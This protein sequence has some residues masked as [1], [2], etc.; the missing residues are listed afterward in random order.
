MSISRKAL[1]FVGCAAL[2]ACSAME[3]PAASTSTPR[4]LAKWVIVSPAAPTIAPGASLALDVE[5]QDASGRDITGQPEAWST[6]DSTIAT[7]SS[8]G[9]VTG[10]A[11]G[12][13]KIFIASGAQ[14]AYA[15]LTVS[16]APPAPR[17]VSVAPATAQVSVHATM[18]LFASVTDA[19]GHQVSNVPV[20]WSSSNTA[21]AMVDTSGAITG[22]APGTASIIV[23]AGTNQA[24]AQL[25]VVTASTVVAPAPPPPAPLQ[26]PPSSGSLYSG[27]NAVSPH[28][29]HIRTMM[30]DFYYGWTSP[31]RTWAGQH[32]D[33]AMSGTGSAWRAVNSSVGHLTYT[34]E[35]TTII[36]GSSEH[37]NAQTAY[38]HDMVAWYAAHGSYS[39][40]NAFLHKAGASHDSASRIVIMIW[41][42]KRW[43]V[44]PADVGA[45]NYQVDRYQRIVAGENGAFVDEA[46]N[47][48]GQTPASLEFPMKTDFQAP[49]TATFAAIKQA[50]GSKVLMLNTAEYSTEFDRANALAAGAVHLEGMNN[51]FHSGIA[52]IWQW[53]EVLANQNVLVDFVSLY[54]STYANSIP[55]TFPHGNSA[56]GAGRMKLWELASY[57]MV[58]PNDPSTLT[59]QLENSWDLPYSSLW[60]RAQEA[61]IGH[62]L[63]ARVQASRGTDPLGQ[64]Y[65]VYTRD[66]D[67]ALVIMRINQG[68]G[69]HSYV[70]G[71]AVTIPLPAT[72][73]WLPLNADGTLGAAVTTITLRNV[74]AAILV[75]KSRL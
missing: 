67:R 71:T 14:S 18:A 43:I 60:L 27:Y 69:T 75:K 38:Y 65:A 64:T 30:T 2:V 28:W 50:I 57:Y 1:T 23:H 59:L 7:V 62:P 11:L 4:S 21:I 73:Q 20:T 41:D 44:N 12:A 68:W 51:P 37:E 61:N 17:W 31:E 55:T 72:D 9:V 54:T 40:E 22:I 3:D 19:Q 35:W 24:I 45:R 34:L 74:E 47:I 5:M 49:Q 33:F 26:P 52:S 8:T 6:S 15:D 56:T 29:P 25:H 48:V 58:V 63:G 13:A 39:I 10:H 70:D 46:A 16:N 36:P 42:S 32:Y 53:V 66:M